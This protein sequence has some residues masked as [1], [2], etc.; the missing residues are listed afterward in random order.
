MR[1]GTKP[2]SSRMLVGFSP[3]GF[4]GKWGR[5]RAC[6]QGRASPGCGEATAREPIPTPACGA[7]RERVFRKL[8]PEG[9]LSQLQPRLCQP[10]R[11]TPARSDQ[12]RQPGCHGAH[13]W[14]N[15]SSRGVNAQ[16]RNPPPPGKR[17]PNAAVPS[18]LGWQVVLL[19]LPSLGDGFCAHSQRQ[20]RRTVDPAG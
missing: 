3:D 20:H 2:A 11:A 1:P 7:L 17:P 14:H 8:C 19:L 6:G 10:A 4:T 15:A 12:E 16:G 9:G 18:L 13:G 5:V